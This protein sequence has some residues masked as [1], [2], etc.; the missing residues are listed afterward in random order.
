MLQLLRGNEQDEKI[1]GTNDGSGC[2]TVQMHLVTL[3]CKFKNG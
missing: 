3:N 2:T 1:M